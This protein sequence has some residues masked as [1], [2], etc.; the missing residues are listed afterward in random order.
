M[1]GE[2][3]IKSSS[4]S[5]VYIVNFQVAEKI[6][7]SCTCPAGQNNLLCKHRL[8]LI[9]GDFSGLLD[10]GQSDKLKSMLA[11]IDRNKIAALFSELNTLDLQIKKLDDQRKKLR[12]EIGLK[13][14]K[15]F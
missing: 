3:Q 4:S 6:A 2:Y 15:G 8:Q 7:I 5:E 9:D 10:A 12:K 1:E 13:F 14:S 11:H